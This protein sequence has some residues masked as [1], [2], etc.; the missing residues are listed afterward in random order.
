MQSNGTWRLELLRLML[1]VQNGF[2][3]TPWVE[4]SC[5]TPILYPLGSAC[6]LPYFC[7]AS[8]RT[9]ECLKKLGSGF[10]PWL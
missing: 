10:L 2:K 6:V 1:T 4:E 7:F 9:I 8:P 3:A 5:V